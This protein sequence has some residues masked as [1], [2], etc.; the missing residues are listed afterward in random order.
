MTACIV[1]VGERAR[2][3]VGEKGSR[4]HV[5]ASKMPAM[6]VYDVRIDPERSSPDS[7][8]LAF[9]NFLLRVSFIG[10]HAHF[11]AHTARSAFYS[12]NF[13]SSFNLIR[14]IIRRAVLFM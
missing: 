7:R 1:S 14:V 12:C 13:I 3:D 8:A 6:C 11:R 9:A 5:E 4:L 10:A 2:G